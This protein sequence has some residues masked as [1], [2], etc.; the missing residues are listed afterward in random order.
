MKISKNLNRIKFFGKTKLSIF[1]VGFGA[2]DFFWNSNISEKDKIGLINYAASNGVNFFDTAQEYGNGESEK[3]IGKALKS[4]RERMFIATKFSPQNHN[5]K[6]QG[7]YN[8]S[9]K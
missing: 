9:M 2:G 3:L 7:L 5:Y 4:D 6:L 1:P 8:L